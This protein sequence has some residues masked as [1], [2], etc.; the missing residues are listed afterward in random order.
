MT[1]LHNQKKDNKFKNKYNQNCQK[2]ELYSSLITKELKKKHLF[3]LVGGEEMGSQGGEDAQQPGGWRARRS[4][5]CVKIN[6]EGQL[7]SKTD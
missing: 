1:S 2:I 3:S 7:G 5:I 6:Q 4:H